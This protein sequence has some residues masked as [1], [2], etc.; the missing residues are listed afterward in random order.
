MAHLRCSIFLNLNIFG[1]MNYL[2]PFVLS[3][4]SVNTVR[5]TD[6]VKCNTIPANTHFVAKCFVNGIIVT[7]MQ[8]WEATSY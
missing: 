8:G 1:Y 6:V 4:K 7:E 3:I 5:G 2:F